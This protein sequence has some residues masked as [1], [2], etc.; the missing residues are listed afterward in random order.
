MIPAQAQKSVFFDTRNARELFVRLR[1]NA[2]RLY[3]LPP[4]FWAPILGPE[5]HFHLGHFSRSDVGVL[6]SMRAAV[7]RLATRARP[8][9]RPRVLD[10]GCGWGGP[11]FQ[12]A[13]TWDASVRCLTVSRAQVDEVRA[14]SASTGTRVSATIY[15]AEVQ[16]FTD[17]G[18]QDVILAY[19]SIDHIWRRDDFIARLRNATRDGGWLL[20]AAHCRAP[21]V[22]RYALYNEFM[23]IPPLDT[24]DDLERMIG[25]SGWRLVDREDCT[26]LTRPVWN[27]WIRNTRRHDAGPF[28]GHATALRQ[29]LAATRDLYDEGLLQ[30]A[31]LC[32]VAE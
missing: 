31:Q 11:A 25:A 13:T 5:L 12:L 26:Q 22:P 21:C 9:P 8:R 1:S 19:E 30:S 24:A 3:E 23:G 10:V 27:L 15:D 28:A 18:V 6:Q 2:A 14:R 16:T 17:L 29:A 7:S 4:R 32:A 20:I